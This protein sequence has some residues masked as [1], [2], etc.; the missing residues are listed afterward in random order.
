[1]RWKVE[2]KQLQ[3]RKL[4]REDAGT[5]EVLAIGLYVALLSFVGIRQICASRKGIYILSFY[6]CHICQETIRGE[7]MEN[8][9]EKQERTRE[10]EMYRA[11]AH[12]MQHP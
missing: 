6:Y 12:A 1:M 3:I 10:I 4:A 11:I 2:S 7:N 9:K 8:W 5:V